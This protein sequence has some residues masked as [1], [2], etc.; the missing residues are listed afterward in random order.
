MN[1]LTY[2]AVL[3]LVCAPGLSPLRD[4]TPI[5]VAE[6]KAVIVAMWQV[7]EENASGKVVKFQSAAVATYVPRGLL[8]KVEY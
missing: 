3:K 7:R 1:P 8:V 4:R 6:I 5:V 2:E